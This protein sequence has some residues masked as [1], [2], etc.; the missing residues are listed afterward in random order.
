MKAKYEELFKI[1]EAAKA[2]RDEANNELR[3]AWDIEDAAVA[4]NDASDHDI[5]RLHAKAARVNDEYADAKRDAI[6]AWKLAGS[7]VDDDAAVEPTFVENARRHGDVSW[8]FRFLSADERTEFD[9]YLV[10]IGDPLA[11]EPGT[12]ERRFHE[13]VGRAS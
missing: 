8:C 11:S 4:P 13:F 12:C 1:A 2:E 5:E 10:A 3:R 6:A 9:D 7:P